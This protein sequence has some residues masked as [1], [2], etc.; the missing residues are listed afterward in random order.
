[1]LR[2]Q[3]HSFEKTEAYYLDLLEMRSNFV[4]ERLETIS[5]DRVP[6]RLHH[7]H[8]GCQIVYFQTKN[9]NSGKFSRVL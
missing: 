3:T 2:E 1:M 9:P 4:D 7:P 6:D 5:P 8:Q